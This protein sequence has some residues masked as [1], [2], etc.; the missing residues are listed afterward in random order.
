M[1][2]PKLPLFRQE[3][4]LS[5]HADVR[6]PAPDLFPLPLVAFERYMLADDPPEYPM[7]FVIGI[8]L[9]GALDNKAFESAVGAALERHPLLCRRVIK[10]PGHGLCWAAQPDP[11]LPIAWDETGGPLESPA[12][13]RIDVMHGTGLRIRVCRGT[14]RTRVT[15]QFHHAATDGIGGMHF[16]GDVLAVYGQLTANPGDE[17]PE[18]DV[19][20]PNLLKDRGGLWESG[21]GPRRGYFGRIVRRL[22]GMAWRAPSP[23]AAPQAPRTLPPDGSPFPAFFTRTFPREVYIGLKDRAAK[24][25]VTVN[26]LLV[27]EMFGTIRDWN[28]QCG[29]DRPRAWHRLIIPLSLRAPR[30]DAIP[31]TNILSLLS[32]TRRAADVDHE[33]ELLQSI[34]RETEAVVG[35]DDR[36]MFTHLLQFVWRVP[37]LVTGLVRAPICQATAILANVGDVRRQFR[38]RFPLKQ[39]KCVAGNVRLEALL[40][41][42]AI[43]HKT[44]IAVSL[45]IYAGSLLVNMQCDPRCYTRLEAEQIADLFADRI[46][47]RSACETALR[48]A[49]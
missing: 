8:D 1:P 33:D 13:E 46:R 42:A 38:A 9:S 23:L 5:S 11:D 45:G 15:F 19:L 6:G 21:E 39:G 2:H 32:L 37:G 40:G 31:A 3:T 41:A 36:F 16:I 22:S 25:M 14:P 28:K 12:A 24:Q 18:L 26:D 48:A 49:S 4:T 17:A 10:V 7:V 44:R 34:H 43:R 47:R 27:L 30:H 29:R 20:S 35:G